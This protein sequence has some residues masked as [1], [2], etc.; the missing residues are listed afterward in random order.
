MAEDMTF[1]EKESYMDELDFVANE[2]FP[3][4][5]KKDSN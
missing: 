3:Y 5:M 1:K 4:M 2:E